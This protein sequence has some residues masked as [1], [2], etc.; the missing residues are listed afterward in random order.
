MERLSPVCGGRW[1]AGF[2]CSG[3]ED[4]LSKITRQLH[5]ANLALSRDVRE[6]ELITTHDCH[7]IRL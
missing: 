7:E 5:V 1:T 2:Q 4:S 6:R 3:R